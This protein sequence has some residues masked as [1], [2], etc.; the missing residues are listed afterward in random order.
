MVLFIIRI[1]IV[2][3]TVFFMSFLILSVVITLEDD[4]LNRF[5]HEMGE[6]MLNSEIVHSKGV[7]SESALDRMIENSGNEINSFYPSLTDD[8][9]LKMFG[10]GIYPNIEP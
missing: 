2:I 5:A 9:R 4:E 1:V 3:A 10:D 8:G 7:F 6:V